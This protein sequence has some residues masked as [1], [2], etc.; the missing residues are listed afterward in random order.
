LLNLSTV[1]VK[2]PIVK[3]NV[4][5][6][7]RLNDQN[8]IASNSL[9]AIRYLLNHFS[10]DSDILSDSIDHNEIVAEAM[11]FGEIH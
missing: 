2:D 8:L 7:W 9:V 11:H 3:I 4:W 6:G 1:A 5:L 10:M